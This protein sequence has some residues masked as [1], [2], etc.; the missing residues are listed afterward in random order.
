VRHVPE[1]NSSIPADVL[2]NKIPHGNRY[3]RAEGDAP[4]DSVTHEQKEVLMSLAV[5]APRPAPGPRISCVAQEDASPTW[6]APRRWRR[7]GQA[8]PAAQI[9][10][11][12][13]R[14]ELASCY[15]MVAPAHEESSWAS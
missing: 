2:A 11:M 6:P 9:S 14:Q 13:R 4:V 3:R 12:A 15:N 5:V 1:P 7:C 10:W 8:M